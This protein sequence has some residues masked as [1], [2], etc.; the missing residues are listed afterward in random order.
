[1]KPATNLHERKCDVMKNRKLYNLSVY[2]CIYTHIQPKKLKPTTR[3]KF[4]RFQ[5]IYTVHFLESGM[6]RRW[7]CHHFGLQWICIIVAWINLTWIC[8]AVSAVCLTSQTV[9][10]TRSPHET[11]LNPACKQKKPS[12]SLFVVPGSGLY[13]K[14]LRVTCSRNYIESF[15]ELWNPEENK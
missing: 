4:D 11:D 2:I 15:L 13:C 1:M 9:G 12:K 5:T 14:Y 7:I 10:N 6:I 3:L 8:C